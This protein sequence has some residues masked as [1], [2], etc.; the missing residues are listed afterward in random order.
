MAG[1]H[2]V[3]TGW[4]SGCGLHHFVTGEHRGDCTKFPP[5]CQHCLYYPA[6]NDGQH[7]ADCPEA[8]DSS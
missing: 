4:C 1:N 2:Q 3:D 5:P 7:R 6:M 8:Q